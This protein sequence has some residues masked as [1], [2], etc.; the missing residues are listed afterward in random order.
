M[1]GMEGYEL[2]NRIRNAEKGSATS[3]PVLAI[4]AS[5]FELND[6][7]AHS[8]GFDGYMLKPLDERVLQLKLA[9]IRKP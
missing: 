5:D 2:V 1:P 4:T 6:E 3:I 7:Q 8:R 9:A